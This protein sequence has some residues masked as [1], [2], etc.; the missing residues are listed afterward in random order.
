MR[1]QLAR[2]SMRPL[3]APFSPGLPPP[4]IFSNC[5]ARTKKSPETCPDQT[6]VYHL[7]P[8]P[9]LPQQQA[10]TNPA[11][12]LP[13]K[14]AIFRVS[15]SSVCYTGSEHRAWREQTPCT[16][17]PI[18]PRPSIKLVLK[19]FPSQGTNTLCGWGGGALRSHP[20]GKSVFSTMARCVNLV[21]SAASS[22]SDPKLLRTSTLRRSGWAPDQLLLHSGGPVTDRISDLPDGLATPRIVVL[23]LLGPK[24]NQYFDAFCQGC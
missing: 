11:R 20:S 7:R 4:T 15:S 17:L 21:F 14:V 16:Q 23:S 19:T 13:R 12:L 10:I 2:S 8:S 5:Y 6:R 3:L 18:E 9:Q 22:G 1:F 24:H